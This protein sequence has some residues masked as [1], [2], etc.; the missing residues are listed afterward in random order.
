M[1]RLYMLVFLLTSFDSFALCFDMSFFQVGICGDTLESISVDLPFILWGLAVVFFGQLLVKSKVN[2][3]LL[4]LFFIFSLPLSPIVLLVTYCIKLLS[5]NCK[6][7]L[8]KNALKNHAQGDVIPETTL[9]KQNNLLIGEYTFNCVEKSL[10]K[11]EQ[12][13]YLEPK[14]MQ[15]LSYLIEQQPRV[16]S[17]EE[18]HSNVWQNQVVTDTAIRRVISKLRNAF[19]DTDTKKPQ[20]IKSQM[21]RGYQFIAKVG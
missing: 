3:Y 11:D 16:V 7:V 8:G 19:S 2:A 12:I 18:L 6:K 17:L 14:M 10:S 9:P 15:V 1:R 20:Y 21:K 13:T 5:D 4:S